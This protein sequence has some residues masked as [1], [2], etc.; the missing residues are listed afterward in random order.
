MELT[1]DQKQLVK[2]AE[3]WMKGLQTM[4]APGRQIS[5]D[6]TNRSDKSIGQ[7]SKTLYLQ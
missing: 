7:I 4:K 5:F 1:D 6:R 3:Q 2:E